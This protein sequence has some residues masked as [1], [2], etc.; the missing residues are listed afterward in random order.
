[1]TNPDDAWVIG[2]DSAALEACAADA[3][4]RGALRVA[5]I[6]VNVA[7]HTPRLAAASIAFRRVL[8]ETAMQATNSTDVRLFSGIDGTAVHAI[9]SGLDK[10]AAQIS[11][12]VHWDAC[13]EAAVEAG[14]TCFLELGPGRALSAMTSHAWPAIPSRSLDDFRTLDGVRA[15]LALNAF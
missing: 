1:M 9:A 4:Q 5:R 10:L 13:L 8:G 7:S 14:A 3:R 12:T 2:A 15:W 6:G 11:Q